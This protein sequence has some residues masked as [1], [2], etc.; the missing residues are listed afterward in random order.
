M[1]TACDLSTHTPALNEVL[2]GCLDQ[3]PTNSEVTTLCVDDKRCNSP[4]P[5]IGVK[6]L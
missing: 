1:I 4:K 3:E 2:I 5:S 6:K